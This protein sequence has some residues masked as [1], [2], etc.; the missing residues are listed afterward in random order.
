M[1]IF[2]SMIVGCAYK[3]FNFTVM[4]RV[5]VVMK[6]VFTFPLYVIPYLEEDLNPEIKSTA[7]SI[8]KYLCYYSIG[9]AD[10]GIYI[11]IFVQVPLT[12]GIK[13]GTMVLSF[14]ISSRIISLVFVLASP[15]LE[16]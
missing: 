13:Y 2:T 12:F 16:Y 14:I 15:D 6:M 9:A 4:F 7:Y 8:V 1:R 10:W 11:I 3:K 5:F